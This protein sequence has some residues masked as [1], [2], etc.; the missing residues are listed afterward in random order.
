MKKTNLVPK[1]NHFVVCVVVDFCS[2]L[3]S[4]R[5]KYVSRIQDVGPKV[6]FDGAQVNPAQLADVASWL[7]PFGI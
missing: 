3:F 4:K 1:K 7:D 5:Q 2:S 6:S